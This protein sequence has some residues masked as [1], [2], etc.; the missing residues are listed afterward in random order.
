MVEDSCCF[1]TMTIPGAAS[2]SMVW[3]LV[4]GGLSVR[5]GV[6]RTAGTVLRDSVG[7]SLLTFLC[8]LRATAAVVIVAEQFL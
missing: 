4:T 7:G 5:G 8:S 3:V 6:A 2:G 1:Q